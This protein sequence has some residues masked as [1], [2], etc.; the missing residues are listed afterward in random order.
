LAAFNSETFPI[1]VATNDGD[2]QILCVIPIRNRR[3]HGIYIEKPVVASTAAWRL[4]ALRK[5]LASSG[6]SVK[7]TCN[8]DETES[9]MGTALPLTILGQNSMILELKYH[10][11]GQF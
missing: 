7:R 5:L 1:D 4:K 8:R 11:T 3:V 9:V 2:T 6:E 10:F